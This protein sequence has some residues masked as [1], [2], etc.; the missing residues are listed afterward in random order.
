[1]DIPKHYSLVKEHEKTF[2]LHDARDK[3]SFHVSKKDLHPAS[4]IKIMKM[5]KLSDGSGDVEPEGKGDSW[6]GRMDDQDAN[7]GKDTL[8]QVGLGLDTDAIASQKASKDYMNSI[9]PHGVKTLPAEERKEPEP[10]PAQEIQGPAPE[11][12]APPQDQTAAST[13]PPSPVQGQPIP[14]GSPTV[15]G[16]N[17]LEAQE[18]KG[19]NMQ[20][21]GQMAQNQGAAQIYDQ[22]VQRQKDS[23]AKSEARNQAREASLHQLSNDIASSKVDP[24]RYWNNK[25]TGSKVM[26]ALGVMISGLGAGM[27][28]STHNMA[29]EALQDN[30]NRDIESQKIDLGKKQ[31]LL[32]D[33]LKIY[34]ELNQAEAATRLQYSAITQGQLAKLAAQTGNP[35]LQGQAMQKIAQMKMGDIPLKQQLMQHDMARQMMGQSTTQGDGG[36]VDSNRLKALQMSGVIPKE[37]EGAIIKESNQLAEVR[38]LRKDFDKSF[39]DLNGKALA[40]SLTP[41]QRDSAIWTLAGKL[42]HASAGR[43]NL[44]DAYKQMNAMFPQAADLGS[45]RAFRSEKSSALFDAMEAGTTTLDKWNLKRPYAPPNPHEGKIA[46]DNKGN[47]LIMQGGKW[48]P[49]RG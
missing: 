11:D 44:E 16:L 26:T 17:S 10:T 48:V 35:I 23:L 39:Q 22:D 13:P 36:P 31:S 6:F 34:G 19:I 41:G 3:S 9:D 49:Y 37:D 8:S 14:S 24:K 43:F 5:Q 1:M 7:G 46:S 20:T 27:S 28:N 29:Y 47:R 40:G 33:N 32:S 2:E 42:Q 15:Q 45:T 18:A 21:Q 38:S 4:Q 30:I 12:V 25:D